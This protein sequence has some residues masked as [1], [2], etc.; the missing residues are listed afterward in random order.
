MSWHPRFFTLALYTYERDVTIQ[1]YPKPKPKPNHKKGTN[2][3]TRNPNSTIVDATRNKRQR[4]A[5]TIV[6]LGFL[7]TG[8]YPRLELLV[9]VIVIILPC[10]H[11]GGIIFT[12]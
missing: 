5:A 11:L 6:G 7:D 10:A 4:I 12:Y 2:Y 9:R 8:Y 3:G 1:Y